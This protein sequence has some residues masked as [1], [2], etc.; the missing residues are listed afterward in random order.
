M[1]RW[2]PVSVRFCALPSQAADCA[3]T[4]N[5][6]LDA[7]HFAQ[8]Y[9]QG[10]TGEGVRIGV[11]DSGFDTSHIAFEGK[12]I[13]DIKSD[14]YENLCGT[15]PQWDKYNH[16]TIAEPSEL[17]LKAYESHPEVKIFSNSWGW[18]R[19]LSLYS[20]VPGENEAFNS[21]FFGAVEKD[22]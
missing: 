17:Y 11:L 10:F 21:I 14:A 5:I 3:A 20:D 8:T 1:R 22:K 4:K 6:H 12:D 18:M 19:C 9:E 2:L 16:G 13:V 7:V 15:D